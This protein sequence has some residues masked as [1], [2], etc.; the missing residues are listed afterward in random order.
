MAGFGR[1]G[2]RID[3]E[4]CSSKSIDIESLK[5]GNNLSQSIRNKQFV[6]SLICDLSSPW[7][8]KGLN[9]ANDFK[10]LLGLKKKMD[11][12]LKTTIFHVYYPKPLTTISGI[13]TESTSSHFH[14]TK[15]RD[16]CY[17]DVPLF[18]ASAL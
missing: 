6:V 11:R 12:L 4:P 13:G 9:K 16:T 3:G 10:I 8:L 15:Y 7:S 14:K 18:H 5:L 1:A 17:R 2:Y